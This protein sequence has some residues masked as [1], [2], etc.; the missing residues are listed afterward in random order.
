MKNLYP[1]LICLAISTIAYSTSLNPDQGASLYDHLVEVNKEWLKITDDNFLCEPAS[2]KNDTKRIQM[3]LKLVEQYLR[4][5]QPAGLDAPQLENRLSVLEILNDYWKTGKFPQNTFHKKRQPYFVDN[6]GTACAVGYLALETGASELVNRIAGEKNY[7]YIAEL[8]NHYPELLDWAKTFGFSVEELAWIQ[9]A[10]WPRPQTWNP[11]GNGGGCDGKINVMKAKDDEMLYLAGE[12]SEVDGVPANSIIAWDGESWHSLGDGVTGIIHD[13][14]IDYF[15]TVYIGGEFYVNGQPEL[16]NLAY[17]KDGAWHGFETSNMTG[18][19]YAIHKPYGRLFVG[20]DFEMEDLNENVIS[21]LAFVEHGE[22]ILQNENGA[23]SVNGPV[24][25]FD[26]NDDHILVAGDFT[27]TATYSS[28]PEINQ[29]ETDYLAYWKHYP[30]YNWVGGF[31]HYFE[32]LGHVRIIDSKIYVGTKWSGPTG[33]G[34]FD[35]GIWKYINSFAKLDE[36]QPELMHGI[37]SH[38]DMI[39]YYG[40]IYFIPVIGSW[41]RGIYVRNGSLSEGA[42]FDA[43][44]TAAES[45]QDQIYF[46]GDFTG[47]QGQEFPGLVASPFDGT[48]NAELLEDK[49]QIEVYHSGDQLYIKSESLQEDLTL[50]IF[51]LNGQLLHSENLQPGSVEKTIYTHNWAAGMYIYNLTGNGFSQSGKLAVF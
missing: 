32:P 51:S 9:P 22:T 4:E 7:A 37:L 25:D 50:N 34:Y 16:V 15:G 17:W 23:F 39:I 46:A 49:K 24:Y 42:D 48:S 12:F 28:D 3:H 2:F 29:L 5:N 27:Q 43:P 19:I 13:I 11:V 10:Y 36:N 38:N 41:S 35:A 6:Y 40:N 30:D 21:N 47:V 14:E 20:G 26:N 45:F 18:V 33:A 1:L 31:D 44:V 8:K